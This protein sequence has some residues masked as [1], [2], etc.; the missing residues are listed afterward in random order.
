M[1]NSFDTDLLLWGPP[2]HLCDGYRLSPGVKQPGR[3]AD[4]APSSKAKVM[5]G[6]LVKYM[7]NFTFTFPWL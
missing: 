2:S 3:E 1:T 7:D 4:D 5:A 6:H